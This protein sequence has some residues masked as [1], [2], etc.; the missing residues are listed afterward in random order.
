MVTNQLKGDERQRQTA[1][2]ELY[3]DRRLPSN[4][5]NWAVAV[6]RQMLASLKKREGSRSNWD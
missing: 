1:F 5:E 3:S 2:E 4:F 6:R